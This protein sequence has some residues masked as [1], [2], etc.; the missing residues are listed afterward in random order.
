[1]GLGSGLQSRFSRAVVSVHQN[2]H[3]QAVVY[4]IVNTVVYLIRGVIIH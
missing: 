2:I 4:V 3:E 1:M